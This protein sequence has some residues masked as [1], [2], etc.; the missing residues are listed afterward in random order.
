MYALAASIIRYKVSFV[1][2]KLKD[3]NHIITMEG[4]GVT[5]HETQQ[6]Q[7][8]RVVF[9]NRTSDNIMFSITADNYNRVVL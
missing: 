8:T 7:G 6:K 1:V 5:M 9:V 2:M 3:T 4:G